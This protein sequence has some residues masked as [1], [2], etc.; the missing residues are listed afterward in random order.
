MLRGQNPQQIK[1]TLNLTQATVYRDVQS[2][3]K[4]SKSWMYD[5]AKGLHVL[6]YQGSIEGIGLT[7][8]E[9]WNK[10]NDP[11]VPEKQKP[12]YLRLIKDCNESIMQLT[13]NG[14]VVMALED[15]T[16]RANNL[17]IDID[18]G[19]QVELGNFNSNPANN[20]ND[21]NN[22]NS[23]SNNSCLHSP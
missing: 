16:R 2:L 15:I 6:A 4:R 10:F 8:F 5:M 19:K 12:A 22:N 13:M 21:N 9:A 20:I 3:T 23:S 14:P 11:Q 18:L 1:K 7:L 17:G